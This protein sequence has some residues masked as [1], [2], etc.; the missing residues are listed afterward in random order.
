MA[1]PVALIVA[2]LTLKGAVAEVHDVQCSC[3]AGEEAAIAGKGH[4]G[5]HA[6]G[7][8]QQQA[9]G[10]EEDVEAAAAGARGLEEVEQDACRAQRLL[11]KGELTGAAARDE[12]LVKLCD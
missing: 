6:E 10:D 1:Q 9:G 7:D 12:E 4:E 11:W 8:A 2:G 3:T 5:Q